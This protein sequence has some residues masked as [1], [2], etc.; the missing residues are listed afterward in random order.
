M[1]RAQSRN[2]AY[3]LQADSCRFAR[4]SL[5]AAFLPTPLSHKA[6]AE[7]KENVFKGEQAIAKSF[8]VVHVFFD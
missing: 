7:A 5:Q 3:R 4:Q 8:H 1:I 2:E 6:S